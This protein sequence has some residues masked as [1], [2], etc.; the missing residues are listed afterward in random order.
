ME[1]R[2]V[3]KQSEVLPEAVFVDPL[4]G[5]LGQTDE[6][7]DGLGGLVVEQGDLDV[8]AVGGVQNGRGRGPDPARGYGITIDS[9]AERRFM[10]A[11][12]GCAVL[13]PSAR[14]ATAG[15]PDGLW[16]R[17]SRHGRPDPG[18][19]LAAVRSAG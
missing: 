19:R 6:V 13:R 11:A 9:S 3:V 15:G 10:N 5:A 12:P 18:L 4:H 8:A 16:V 1:H 7:G 17:L 14:A 2:A